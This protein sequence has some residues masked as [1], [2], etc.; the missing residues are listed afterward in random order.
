VANV[1]AGNPQTSRLLQGM[2]ANFVAHAAD[3]VT[4]SRKALGAICGVV[5]QYAA[6]LAFGEALFVMG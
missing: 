4:A 2:R 6:M 1:T 3:G 5:E